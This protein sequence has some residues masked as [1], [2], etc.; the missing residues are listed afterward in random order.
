MIIGVIMT[1][2]TTGAIHRDSELSQGQMT[3]DVG[4]FIS[5]EMSRGMRCKLKVALMLALVGQIG[6]VHAAPSG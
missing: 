6:A 3:G 2:V 4:D 1:G 5:R